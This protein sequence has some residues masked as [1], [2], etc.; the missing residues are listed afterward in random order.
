MHRARA[1]GR[2]ATGQDR[3]GP[4]RRRRARPG[5]AG[6][7]ALPRPSVRLLHAGHD[8]HRALAARPQPG[9]HRGRGPRGDLRPDLPLHRVRE[10]RAGSVL[11]AARNGGR[12]NDRRVRTTRPQGR[13]AVHPRPGHVRRR[14]QPARHAARRDPAQPARARPD[15]L[16]RRDRGPRASARR[17][18]AHR[19]GPG[20]AR[21]GLD[22]D[23]G[24]GRAGC[25]GDRQ[26]AVPGPGDRLRRGHRPVLGQGRAGADRGRV[27]AAAAG[28][29]TPVRRWIPIR[30]SSATTCLAGRATTSSTGRPG[31]RRRP[32]PSSKPPR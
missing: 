10:H 11:W 20:R 13:R 9:S 26:G 3:R 31:T 2:W 19:C 27:R 28:Q 22:A 15:P 21:A 23:A 18:R 4:G 1:D 30:R 29:S 7:R 8:A 16:R 14:H 24:R 5:P 17:G 25:A 6:L 12:R 32:M